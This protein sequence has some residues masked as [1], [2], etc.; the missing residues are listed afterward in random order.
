MAKAK[1]AA[2]LSIGDLEGMIS[3]DGQQVEI[4]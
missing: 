3:H 1:A 4:S 2:R